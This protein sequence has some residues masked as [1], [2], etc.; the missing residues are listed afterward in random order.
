[1]SLRAP[2]LYK[3][4]FV[5]GYE[6]YMKALQS[7]FYPKD[8][9]L[10]PGRTFEFTK[11]FTANSRGKAV[12]NACQWYWKEYKGA[13]GQINDIMTINDPYDEVRYSDTFS[14][15]DRKNRY[16]N[17]ETIE[18]IIKDSDGQLTKEES[19]GDKHHPPNSV[20][21]V[22]R[23]RKY[24]VRVGKNLYQSP[25]TRTLYYVTTEISKNGKR[26]R[27]NNKLVTKDLEKAEREIDRRFPKEPEQPSGNWKDI[28]D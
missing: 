28:E 22:K 3:A 8:A 26:V 5:I 21:R 4:V 24:N 19:T 14:C 27:K 13:W 1:M 15:S 6:E 10:T 11:D 7:G 23:R 20:K 18:K 2:E 17:T 9:R 12:Y 25:S 16:L